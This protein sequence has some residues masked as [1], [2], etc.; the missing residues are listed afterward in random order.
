[1]RRL[2]I[3]AVLL[4]LAACGD[5][6]A[7]TGIN[8]SPVGSYELVSVDGQAL[9]VD[10][11]WSEPSGLRHEMTL[12]VGTLRI[13]ND[14]RWE[15]ALTVRAPGGEGWID[16]SGGSWEEETRRFVLQGPSRIPWMPRMT[17]EGLE[18][19]REE[20]GFSGVRGRMVYRRL[21]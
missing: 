5:D 17:R 18:A 21:P 13:G 19:D 3:A 16:T 20:T 15:E 2:L 4:T 6:G 1:M 10:A 9:P 12:T 14:G 8:V 11:S 7:P